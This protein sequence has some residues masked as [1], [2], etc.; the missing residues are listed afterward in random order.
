MQGTDSQWQE[1]AQVVLAN[2]GLRDSMAHR[3]RLIVKAFLKRT[4]LL[5]DT[6]RRPAHGPR[7]SASNQGQPGCL[8]AHKCQPVTSC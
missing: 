8:F 5:T 7:V 6:D 4:S 2:A 3:K 1:L